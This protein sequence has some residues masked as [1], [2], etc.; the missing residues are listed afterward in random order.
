[1][2]VH[3]VWFCYFHSS[4]FPNRIFMT[5]DEIRDRLCDLLLEI[6]RGVT[7]GLL[8]LF[9]MLPGDRHPSSFVRIP[10]FIVRIVS[11]GRVVALGSDMVLDNHFVVF[12]GY[13]A[14]QQ[15]VN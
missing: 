14:L 2:A 13:R 7:C 1:M 12:P 8:E 11:L 3:G 15:R 5:A 4:G 10:L 6:W 9:L